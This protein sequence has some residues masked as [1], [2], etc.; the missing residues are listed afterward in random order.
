MAIHDGHRQ[1]MYEKLEQGGI[2]A[3]HEWLELL[4]Y[5]ALPRRNTNELAHRL[6]EH[7]GSASKVFFGSQE[8]LEE[9]EGVGTSVAASIRA[10]GHFFIRYKYEETARYTGKYE[11]Q[12]FSNFVM[13]EY[14]HMPVE[15]VDLYLLGGDGRVKK[16]RRFTKDESEEVDVRPEEFA[17][18]LTLEEPAGVVVVHNHPS[19]DP[20]PSKKDEDTTKK[21][22]VLCSMH[23]VMFCDHIICGR[24]GVYSYYLSGRMKEV[25]EEYSVDTIVGAND[26]KAGTEQKQ[27]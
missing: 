1:R 11:H 3:E 24:H 17:F 27:E 5:T 18:I 15:V 22:Q 25:G 6:I 20:K 21:C 9:V 10:I 8:A 14:A 7:F 19:G 16:R 13:Q 26:A 12:E 4:L 2:L 23:N